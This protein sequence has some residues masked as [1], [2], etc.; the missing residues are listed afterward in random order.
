MP[1]QYTVTEY[2]ADDIEKLD[3]MS[4]DEVIAQLEYIESSWLPHDYAFVPDNPAKR[5]VTTYTESQYSAA[6][7]HKAMQKAIEM[8]QEQA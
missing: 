7:L 1:R 6:K 2:D 3:S 4:K 8:L 5:A